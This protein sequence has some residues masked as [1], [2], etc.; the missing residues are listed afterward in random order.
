MTLSWKLNELYSYLHL[1]TTP[2]TEAYK[3]IKA[4]GQLK[5]G[6]LHDE[7]VN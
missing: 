4:S 1:Q 6:D 5:V 2:I 3:Y 7:A